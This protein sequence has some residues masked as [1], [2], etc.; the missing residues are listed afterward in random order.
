MADAPGQDSSKAPPA[1]STAEVANEGVVE[2]AISQSV[3]QLKESAHSLAAA[4]QT[5]LTGGGGEAQPETPS[6]ASEA[7]AALAEAKAAVGKL[8]GV[9]ARPVGKN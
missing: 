7:K 3:G 8:A 1:G 4:L 6:K 2:D 9:F 5:K